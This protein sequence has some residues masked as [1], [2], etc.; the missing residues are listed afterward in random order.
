[1]D[2]V[3]LIVAILLVSPFILVAFLLIW[4]ALYLRKKDNEFKNKG[5]KIKLKV[6]DVLVDEIH[7]ENGKVTK[8]LLTIF[9]YYANGRL[10]ELELPTNKEYDIGDE[11]EG[12]YLKDSKIDK[13]SAK[14]IGF[15]KSKYAEL[16]LIGFAIAIL[17]MVIVPI[18]LEMK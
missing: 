3:I 4:L 9:E 1:M 8:E 17:A 7:H 14:G 13:I 15:Y 5:E 10:Q 12:Y 18:I 6:K 11:I 16:V 2:I